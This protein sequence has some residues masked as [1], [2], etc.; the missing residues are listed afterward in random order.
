MAYGAVLGVDVLQRHLEH[1][2]AA[3]ANAMNFRL[4]FVTRRWLF[5]FAARLRFGHG[6]IL[7]CLEM[8]SLAQIASSGCTIPSA[9]APRR[10]VFP[11]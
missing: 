5:G 11:I 8:L 1:V 6:R 2:V 4:R 9:D 10:R 7:T 3:D